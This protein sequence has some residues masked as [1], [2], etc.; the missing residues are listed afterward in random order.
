[1]VLDQS[2]IKQ[3]HVLSSHLIFKTQHC[4]YLMLQKHSA[5]W[6]ILQTSVNKPLRAYDFDPVHK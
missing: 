5:S 1:M 6:Q 3:A 4:Q 2:H